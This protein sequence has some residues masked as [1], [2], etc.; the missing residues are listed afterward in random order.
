MHRTLA[1]RGAV[2]IVGIDPHQG[3]SSIRQEV[4]CAFGQERM[5]FIVLVG[6]PMP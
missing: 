6:L 5:T 3:H 2:D 1:V 4:G